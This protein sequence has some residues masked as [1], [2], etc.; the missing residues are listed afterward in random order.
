M[1]NF[2]D[3]IKQKSTTLKDKIAPYQCVMVGNFMLYVEGFTS[4]ISFSTQNV[5]FK[6]KGG[7]ITALGSNLS[8]KDMS[9]STIT[10]VGKIAQVE[11]V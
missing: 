1:F 8:I 2:F 7:A 6:V 5:S 11:C 4:L 10:I 9:P 3:E